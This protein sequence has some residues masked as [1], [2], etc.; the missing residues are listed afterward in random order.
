M[1]ENIYS[2]SYDVIVLGAGA[3]GLMAAAS[4]SY[5]RRS[6]LILEKSNMAG[7]KILMSGGG[8]CNFTNLNVS[9]DNFI[10]KNPHFSTSASADTNQKI[11]STWSRVIASPLRKGNMGSCF[12]LDPRGKF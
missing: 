9:S 1:A 6:V 10:S 8:K 5:R 2:Q 12:A 4:A 3:A 11:L 7:K